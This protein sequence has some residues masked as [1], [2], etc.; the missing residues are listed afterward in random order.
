[1]SGVEFKRGQIWYRNPKTRAAGHIQAGSRPVVIVSN[2]VCNDTSS[3]LLVVPC[4]TAV[5]RNMPTH[6]LFTLNGEINTAMTEQAGPV[7]VG[8]LENCI[9]FLEPYIMEQVDEALKVS[10][11]LKPTPSRQWYQNNVTP[12]QEAKVHGVSQG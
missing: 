6:V 1:M 4:T 9:Y 11:G 5:K 10:F 2:N 12:I 7:S 8:E 3:V